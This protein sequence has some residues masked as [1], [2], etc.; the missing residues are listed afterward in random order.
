MP[1][2]G[3]GGKASTEENGNQIRTEITFDDKNKFSCF[4]TR[5]LKVIGTKSASGGKWHPN[6]STL[7]SIVWS[8]LYD[9]SWSAAKSKKKEYYIVKLIVDSVFAPWEAAW[10]QTK[11]LLICGPVVSPSSGDQTASDVFPRLSQW[12]KGE[13]TARK[14]LSPDQIKCWIWLLS[15]DSFWGMWKKKHT[16]THSHSHKET[17]KTKNIT[18]A[19]NQRRTVW[20]VR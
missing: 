20:A 6:L 4:T 7:R 13:W 17:K 9:A 12:S 8:E 15:V 2:F 14:K 3:D 19:T 5:P 18:K 11:R 10:Y 16:H 1:H